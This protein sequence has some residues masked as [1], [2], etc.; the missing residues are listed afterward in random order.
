MIKVGERK[1][2]RVSCLKLDSR[3]GSK[4]IERRFHLGQWAMSARLNLTEPQHLKLVVGS[5]IK[6]E[7]GDDCCVVVVSILVPPA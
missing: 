2:D 6:A 1:V 4:L 5:Y 7:L 3:L